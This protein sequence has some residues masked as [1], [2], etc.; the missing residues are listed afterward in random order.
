MFLQK[1]Y[2]TK[3]LVYKLPESLKGTKRLAHDHHAAAYN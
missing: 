3:I 2:D 1:D